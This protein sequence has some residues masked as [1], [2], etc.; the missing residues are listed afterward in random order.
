MFHSV[1]SNPSIYILV[2]LMALAIAV[3]LWWFLAAPVA[4]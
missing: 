3:L 4:I 1:L 2:K